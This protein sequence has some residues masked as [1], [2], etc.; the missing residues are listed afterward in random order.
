[1]ED[2]KKVE[3]NYQAEFELMRARADILKNTR[4]GLLDANTELQSQFN[5]LVQKYQ[6]LEKEFVDSAVKYNSLKES[7]DAVKV[8]TDQ[9]IAYLKV[10]VEQLTSEIFTN[11]EELTPEQLDMLQTLSCEEIHRLEDA[12][13]DSVPV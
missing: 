4:D 6:S 11:L 8:I 3:I 7:T 13:A 10:Q 2:E 1:M 9:E 5:L 12:D